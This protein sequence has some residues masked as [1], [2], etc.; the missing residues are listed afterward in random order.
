MNRYLFTALFVFAAASVIYGEDPQP[1]GMMPGLRRRALTLDID[2]RVLEPAAEAGEPLVQGR[3]SPPV[4]EVEVVW[5]ETHRKLTIPGSPVG[6]KLVGSNVVVAVQF[7]PFI[8]RRGQNVLIAQ[9]QIWINVPNE[10]MRYHT[11]IQTIPLEFNEPIY[12][13]PLG[14]SHQG[15]SSIEIMLTV[16][17]Y[18]ETNVSSAENAAE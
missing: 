6:I 4:Q 15:S 14:H 17:P 5:S 7:T 10:G 16:N 3:G 8:R 12:F 9:G 18:S 13:F 11:S 2:T 1:G